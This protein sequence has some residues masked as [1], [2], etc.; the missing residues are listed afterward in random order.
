MPDDHGMVGMTYFLNP[1]GST[2]RPKV[3]AAMA[4]QIG[5]D[6]KQWLYSQ[7]SAR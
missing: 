7:G 1:L 2:T 5:E 6:D 4:D 3:T